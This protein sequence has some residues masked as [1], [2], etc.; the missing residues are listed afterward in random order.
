VYLTLF[1]VGISTIVLSIISSEHKEHVTLFKTLPD[2]EQFRIVKKWPLAETRFVEGLEFVSDTELLMSSGSYGGSHIEIL[3]LEHEPV[4]TVRSQAL[5]SQY[6]GEGVSKVGEEYLMMTYQN[7]KVFR[8]NSAFEVTQIMDMPRQIREGWGMTRTS[9]GLLI[10]SDG[11]ATLFWIDP[12]DFSIVRT[13]QVEEDG[14]PVQEVNELE[15]V[16]DVLYANIFGKDDVL[17]IEPTTGNVK[18]RL[19]LR[20][21]INDEKAFL[22]K[23][24]INWSTYDKL[25]NVLNGIAYH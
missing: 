6:F 9:D 14:I 17:V 15:L 4:E 18:N 8:F 10:V 5:A 20:S 21:L 25:N 3:S 11:S 16:G 7:R 19:K 13:L 22:K 24:G 23:E 12:S 2:G 1:F